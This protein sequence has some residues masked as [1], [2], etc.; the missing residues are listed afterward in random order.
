[1]TKKKTRSSRARS[2]SSDRSGG[3]NSCRTKSKSR[4]FASPSSQQT[5]ESYRSAQVLS[6]LTNTQDTMAGKGKNPA[7]QP[8]RRSARQAKA[9]NGDNPDVNADDSNA[10]G[11]NSNANAPGLNALDPQVLQNTNAMLMQMLQNQVAANN[12]Q[13]ANA[14]MANMLQMMQ[15]SMAGSA[16]VAPETNNNARNAAAPKRKAAP[17]APDEGQ[18]ANELEIAKAAKMHKDAKT[19]GQSQMEVLI[20]QVIKRDVWRAV[21]LAY[22][23][24]KQRKAA[25][26]CLSALNLRD[27]QGNSNEVKK[28]RQDWVDN[29]FRVV[30]GQT[31]EHRGYVQTQIRGA[32]LK[33]MEAND[34]NF[35]PVEKLLACLER[36]IDLD[37]EEDAKVFEVYWDTL[38]PKAAGNKHDWNTAHSHYV[39]MCDGAP[40]NKPHSLYVTPSTEAF[41][42]AVCESNEERWAETYR[43]KQLNPGKQVYFC[44]DWDPKKGEPP[45]VSADGKYVYA[46][47]DKFFGKYTDANKGQSRNPGWTKAGRDRLIELAALNKEARAK[48]QTLALEQAFLDKL[49]AK[50]GLTCHSQEEENRNKRRKNKKA[51]VV[52]EEE[53]EDEGEWDQ[54]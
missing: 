3:G 31:N 51:K 12:G 39:R 37:N 23:E 48:P 27:F 4:K 14:N 32:A 22:G 35:P 52:E 6:N 1:M 21:K 41:L 54:I 18:L 13:P 53:E 49:R 30:T 25:E 5:A 28:R 11:N 16:H 40:P 20:K 34:G 17:Y 33:Y 38:I 43:Q 10:N 42:V 29:Y 19:K 47:G 9:Q 7:Q 46:Y 8:S 50:Y 2:P 26:L 44:P 36:K 45:L 24:K 15:A